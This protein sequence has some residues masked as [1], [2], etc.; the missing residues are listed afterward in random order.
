MKSGIQLVAGYERKITNPFSNHKLLLVLFIICLIAIPQLSLA[1]EDHDWNAAASFKVNS[2]ETGPPYNEIYYEIIVTLSWEPPPRPRY[3]RGLHYL[4][5]LKAGRMNVISWGNTEGSFRRLSGYCK[6][7]AQ[8][9]AI[10]DNILSTTH[11]FTIVLQY[12]IFDERYEMSHAFT[13]YPPPLEATEPDPADGTA[14]TLPHGEPLELIW[15]LGRRAST[16]DVYFS[17]NFHDVNE[18]TE[19]AFIGNLHLFPVVGVPD[20]DYPNDLIPGKT[21]Y[22]RI[23]EVDKHGI[24]YEG[25]VW[26]FWTKSPIQIADPNLVC[27]WTF[28]LSEGVHVIDW[29]GH[30]N[31]GTISSEPKWV[32]GYDGRALRFMTEGDYVT[33]SLN[34]TRDWPAGT[35]AL[36]VK[37]DT[38]SQDAWSGVFSSYSATSAGLQ[39]D[40]DGGS[41]GNYQVDPGGLN[42]GAVAMDWIHLALAFEGLSAKLYYNGSWMGSGTLKD[43]KFNQF[44]LGIDR[45]MINSFFGTLDDLQIYDYDLSQD[46]IKQVMR[47]K[48]SI[49]WEPSPADGSVPDIEQATSL[50]WSPGDGASKHDIYFGTNQSSMIDADISDKTGIYRGSQDLVAYA[51]PEILESGKT[52]YWRID[53]SNDLN[54]NTPWKGDIW[55]FTIRPEIAYRPYPSDGSKL[56]EQNVTLSWMSGSTGVFHDVYFGTDF[57]QVNSVDNSDA[58]GL[59]HGRV[60]GTSYTPGQLD[61]DRTYYWRIDE[62]NA[63]GTTIHKGNVWSFTVVNL[64]TIEYQVSSSEDDGYASSDDLQNLSGDFLRVGR[65]RFSELPYYISG[66]VFKD[67]N[68]PRGTEI[69]SAH[70]KIQSHDSSLAD[71]V[72]GKIAAEAA[73]D[74][75]G[76]STFHSIG[77]LTMTNISVDWDLDGPWLA[78][79]WYTSPDIV[80][81]I[82]EVIN[83]DGWQPNNSLTILYSTRVR[84][85]GY[86]NFSS[87]DRSSDSAP[88]LEITYIP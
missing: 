56:R 59:Y 71:V 35:V 84:E 25:N 45:N 46:E 72:H 20:S 5:Y 69:I 1:E 55:S 11:P 32:D 18:G 68:I 17:N 73:D 75:A 21:Y 12:T 29:S 83:S 52:Y 74:A 30:D 65:S 41:P 47:I 42:F 53:E 33:C 26:N 14:V 81:I 62:V 49:A 15:T 48:P 88:I 44:A 67:I 70:L 8:L 61:R 6:T 60:D 77:A 2:E 38:V 80:G 4:L 34:Q 22:W 86:R 40:V 37:A 3:S 50:V 57:N 85:G 10:V 58:S 79:T 87:Y 31:D 64:E 43:T 82:Q 27:W 19:D 76:F 66:M 36:W 23:D 28:D 54:E 63:D 78:N 24:K 39:I 9:D 51:P 16:H 13:W 7:Y